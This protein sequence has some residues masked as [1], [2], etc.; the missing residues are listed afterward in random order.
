[1]N[2]CAKAGKDQQ[3]NESS[4]DLLIK[5]RIHLPEY[6]IELILRV[7]FDQDL[8]AAIAAVPEFDPGTEMRC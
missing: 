5:W 4:H 1:M 8:P 3:G 2:D 7:I 6:L